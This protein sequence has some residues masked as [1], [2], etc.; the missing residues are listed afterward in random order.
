MAEGLG[1]A[2]AVRGGG[3][4]ASGITGPFAA[5]I[6]AA[7]IGLEGFVPQDADG[8]GGA[9]LYSGEDGI[10]IVVAPEF[11][12]QDGQGLRQGICREGG[13]AAAAKTEKS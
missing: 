4:D 9:A 13:Q 7:D 8:R 3:E 2:D 5:G 12:A 6:Q 11:P 1:A 10:G